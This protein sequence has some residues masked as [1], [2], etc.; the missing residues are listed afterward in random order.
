MK[1]TLRIGLTLAVLALPAVAQ[2]QDGH[3][4]H[5]MSDM[6]AARDGAAK[7]YMD[8]MSKM[9]RDMNAAMTGDPDIDFAAMMIAH[10][11]GAI[12]MAK[13]QLEYGRDPELRKLS[14]EIIK[15]QERE[16]AFMKDWLAKH[17]RPTDTSH[18]HH[19]PS[20]MAYMAGM[21]TMDKDMNAAM[22]GD[23]D[24]DFVVMMIPHHQGAID[25]AKVQLEH[26]KDA[27]LHRLSGEIIKAQEGEIAFM[28]DWLTRR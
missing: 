19:M 11:Q 26:G 20:S 23:P 4:Q 2:A 1:R 21:A 10:H 24:R 28:K 9:S 22:T 15:A 16:I 5:S 7:A 27:E 25:M 14:G 6:E 8:G 3:S 18:A 12:D 13:V 17:P